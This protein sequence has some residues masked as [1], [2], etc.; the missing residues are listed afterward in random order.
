MTL[1]CT[2]PLDGSNS[3]YQRILDAIHEVSQATGTVGVRHTSVYSGKWVTTV[4]GFSENDE[5][6]LKLKVCDNCHVERA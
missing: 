4:E 6:Q 5:M 3:V 1:I 2:Y